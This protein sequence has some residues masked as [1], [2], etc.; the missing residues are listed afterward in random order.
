MST[1]DVYKIRCYRNVKIQS[2]VFSNLLLL[3]RKCPKLLL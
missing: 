1:N 2:N 3:D